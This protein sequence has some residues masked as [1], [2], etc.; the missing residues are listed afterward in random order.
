V[1]RAILEL[2]GYTVLTARDGL[3]ALQLWQRLGPTIELLMADV[4]CR[5]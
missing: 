5:G 4:V 3:E 1:A 2:N